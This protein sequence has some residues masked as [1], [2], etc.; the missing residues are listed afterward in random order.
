MRRKRR[1]FTI[2][3]A[4]PLFAACAML[5]EGNPATTPNPKDWPCGFVD[6]TDC[7]DKTCC[8]D[9]GV[10]GVDTD[11]PYCQFDIPSDPADPT[12]LARKRRGPRTHE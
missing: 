8:R 9:H 12:M 3:L 1:L 2:L 11:G 10:C 6:A 5:R 4:F 7:G